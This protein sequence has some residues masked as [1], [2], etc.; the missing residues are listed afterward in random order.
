MVINHYENHI[1]WL[2]IHP[3]PVSSREIDSKGG[4]LLIHL[5]LFDLLAVK[6]E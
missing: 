4:D 2:H 5:H 6:C 1:G 3:D